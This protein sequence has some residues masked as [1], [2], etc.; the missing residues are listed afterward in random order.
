MPD[1]RGGFWS[2]TRSVAKLAFVVFIVFIIVVRVTGDGQL[3]RSSDKILAGVAGG[4]ADYFHLDRTMVRVVWA[5]SALYYGVGA[6]AYILG[7]LIIPP[8]PF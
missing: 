2:A 6:G 8:S 5:V 7:W 1:D 3:Y 4:V